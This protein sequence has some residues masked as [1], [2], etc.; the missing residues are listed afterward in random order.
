M[1]VGFSDQRTFHYPDII[2]ARP[3]AIVGVG[4]RLAGQ[5]HSRYSWSS[6]GQHMAFFLAK[7]SIEM[8]HLHDP[9][10][11]RNTRL[12]FTLVELLVVIAIIGTLVG[13]LLP[14]VQSAREAARNNSCKN[15][16]SQLAKA[17]MTRETSSKTLP[18]Y[19]NK[20]GISG[21]DFVSRASWPVLLFPYIEQN[22]LYEQFNNGLQNAGLLSTLPQIEIF[23]CPSNPPAIEG[24]PNMSY[25]ANSGYRYAWDRGANPTNQR[26]NFEN[27]ADGVFLDR[28]R[29]V[30]VQAFNVPWK[31]VNDV[32]DTGGAPEQSMTT[33]YIQSKGDGT[34]K[35]LMFSES[36][37]A[38][39]YA[40]TSDD[41]TSTID[42]SH[43][44]G[45][46]WVQPNAVATDTRLRVNGSKAIPEYTTFS[47]MTQVLTS[48]TPNEQPEK[49]R[50][51]IASSF[52][53][54]G[55][56][57]AFVGTQVSFLT[58]QVDPQVFAQ[59]MTSNRNQSG[60]GNPPNYESQ[61]PAPEDGTY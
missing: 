3:C 51:G 12:A 54:G 60:L 61:L 19:I 10:G 2:K 42:A 43:H 48:E 35:T 34:T 59:L 23:V 50:P 39:Y 55:V 33:A 53:P 6:W 29:T 8:R 28:T 22:Q 13:L 47:G 45:F 16:I 21:S 56:N 41:Y 37:A 9:S 5:L 52:H 30:D 49:P 57:V 31:S 17:V 11:P 18:G 46:T 25:V 27:P 40:Y 1:L 15:N 32:R 7:E 24:A 38:L 36:L 44:F 58:D 20:L 4:F 14:A 26:L